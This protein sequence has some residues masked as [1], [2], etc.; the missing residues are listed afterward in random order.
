[1]Q[2][3]EFEPKAKWPKPGALDLCFKA[4]IPLDDVIAHLR[5]TG[6]PA[7]GGPVL[8]TGA[9]SMVRSVYVR[10]PDQT[11]IEISEPVV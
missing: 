4:K 10:D 5:E 11:L 8:R 2:G 1:V 6:V 9:V 3:H 7:V